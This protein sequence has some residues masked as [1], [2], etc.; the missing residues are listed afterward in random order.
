MNLFSFVNMEC[1]SSSRCCR[2]YFGIIQILIPINICNLHHHQSYFL[3]EIWK[4]FGFFPGQV[5]RIR[6]KSLCQQTMT[7]K[8]LHSR[9]LKH[10]GNLISI[11]ICFGR[12]QFR[13]LRLFEFALLFDLHHHPLGRDPKALLFSSRVEHDFR[14]LISITIPRLR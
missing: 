8:V 13:H 9:C 4:D 2:D 11:N 6:N 10:F 7:K 12:R 14:L 5:M 3:I 1:V